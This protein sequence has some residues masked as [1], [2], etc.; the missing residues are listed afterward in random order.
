VKTKGDHEGCSLIFP[1]GSI[2]DIGSKVQLV[3]Y[4][5]EEGKKDER[6]GGEMVEETPI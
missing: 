3:M 2:A 1:Q 5:L 6:V 4:P